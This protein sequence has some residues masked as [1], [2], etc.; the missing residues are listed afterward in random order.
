MTALIFWTGGGCLISSTSLRRIWRSFFSEKSLKR[1]GWSLAR[2][3]F[4][5]QFRCTSSVVI[6][7]EAYQARTRSLAEIC[8]CMLWGKTILLTMSVVEGEDEGAIPSR[9]QQPQLS[10]LT[11]LPWPGDQSELY[12]LSC[13]DTDL[14]IWWPGHK[15]TYSLWHTDTDLQIWWPG[16]KHTYSLWHTDTDLQIWWP[17]HKHIY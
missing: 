16:H 1:E 11:L 4:H 7:N 5:Q 8:I 12:K 6:K 2:V 13:T 3:V 17:G 14:L 9:S 15:H 10:R